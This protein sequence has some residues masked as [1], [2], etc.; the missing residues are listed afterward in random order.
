MRYKSALRNRRC[1]NA[2]HESL[3][4]AAEV[5]EANVAEVS[6]VTK[7]AKTEVAKE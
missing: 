4:P 6:K 1:Q 5:A 7:V 2:K 3:Y